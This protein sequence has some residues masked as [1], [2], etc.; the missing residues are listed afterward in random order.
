MAKVLVLPDHIASQ[1]AAG[2][3]V[4]RPASVVKEL[5]ENCLDAGAS[6]I[7]IAISADCRDIRVADNGQGM[8]PED[9]V[10]A[11][12]RHATSKLRSADDLWAL[13]TLGFRGEALP[14]IASISRFTCYT[15]THEAATGTKVTSADGELK[16]TETGCSPGTV[17]EVLELFYNTPARLKFMKKA[18]TEFGH[19][20]EIVQ[21]LAIAYQNVAFTL[22]ND[23]E[24]VMRTSGQGALDG[25][26]VQAG[27]FSGR[28]PLVEVL[29]EES[30]N[31]FSIHGYLAK[32]T[33]FR[34]DRKGILTIVNKRAVRCPLTL[35]ALDYAYSDLIPRGRYPLAVVKIELDPSQ[36]DVNIHPTKKEL[37]YSNGNGIYLSIQR[38]LTRALRQEAMDVAAARAAE[39]QAAFAAAYAMPAAPAQ[40][41]SS[42]GSETAE[43]SVVQ[44]ELSDLDRSFLRTPAASS[45]ARPAQLSFNPQHIAYEESQTPAQMQALGHLF[46]QARS[47]QP[48]QL[49]TI[50]LVEEANQ[51][52]FT[53]SLTYKVS[54]ETHHQAPYKRDIGDHPL[55]LHGNNDRG[56]EH[57]LGDAQIES[58]NLPAAGE[59]FIAEPGYAEAYELPAGYRMM[60]YLKNT[61][62]F[63]ETHEGLEII[64]QH[65]AHERTL[66]ERL[67]AGQNSETPGRLNDH[68]QELLVSAPLNLTTDQNDVLKQSTDALAKLGFKFNW[69]DH[70]QASV[71]QLPVQLAQVNYVPVIQKMIDELATVDATNMELE[72]TKSIACQSAIKNG[73]PL[74]Q[75]DIL[76]LVSD[77][78]KT[79]RRDT[80]PHG[81]PVRLKYT[82][83]ELFEL[84]HPA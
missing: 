44:K 27:F 30:S 10:L 42:I 28:E 58:D 68:V 16:A 75:R 52:S 82:M 84:F 37:K 54:E 56:H 40:T 43:Q 59:H 66:Y 31:G 29:V 33:H 63:F 2:E 51:I 61:Y 47:A 4:E 8:E 34:G 73:M 39:Q 65:I 81:R 14:S 3:V 35:K 78:L 48:D 17:M 72:A 71:S 45:Q 57:G 69:D 70:G 36:V 19:I 32:P 11:F 62:I 79:E 80:C 23:G 13:N 55:S 53:D 15:R 26:I 5:V 46:P 77:W 1:I 38:A 18:A 25:T 21:S 9:A 20:E 49:E 74:S 12:Q 67:L 83:P 22:I 50:G 64:E 6:E 60:G 76:K 7:E 41:V 24:V